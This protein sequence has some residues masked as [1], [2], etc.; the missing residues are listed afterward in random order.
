[1]Q[2]RI[3]PSVAWL[4][5]ATRSDAARVRHPGCWLQEREGNLPFVVD[6]CLNL[7]RHIVENE[8]L[9]GEVIRLDSAHDAA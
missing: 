1:M 4:R 9:N 8:M 3:H 2:L 7:V 6:G 5:R